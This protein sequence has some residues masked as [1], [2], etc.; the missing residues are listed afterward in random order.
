MKSRRRER[1]ER[2]TKAVRFYLSVYRYGEWTSNVDII[3][4]LESSSRGSKSINS[5]SRETLGNYM[6]AVE[7]SE[8]REVWVDGKR[9]TQYRILPREE[10]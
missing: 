10:E 9:Q 8:R 1:R 5:I 4:H 6:R 2:I 7:D 3:L